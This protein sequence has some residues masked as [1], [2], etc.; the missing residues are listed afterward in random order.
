MKQK[1][2]HIV[3]FALVALLA[4]PASAAVS[5]VDKALNSASLQGSGK[6]Y[7][8]GFHIYD[9]SFYRAANFSSPEFAL[10]I[11]YHKSFTGASIAQR[12][13]DEMKKIGV[14][15]SQANQWGKE[16]T[17]FLP[18]VEAGHTLTAV[19][20]P[21]QGTVFYHDGRR[22]A[23]VY[24]VDFSKAFFGIWLDSKT[25]V[26]KLRKE[27]LGQSCTPPIFNEAC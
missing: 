6:L 17:N 18:D 9:A 23:Q 12:S 3:A 25:S 20:T 14:P 24:G 7:W 15:E 21:T 27:L 19:Y 10:E 2:F 22:I 4:F 8:W 11:R 5:Q 26:P 16:L 1:Y 13:A